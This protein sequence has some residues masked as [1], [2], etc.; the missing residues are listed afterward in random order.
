MMTKSAE[1]HD[2]PPLNEHQLAS[3]V[4]T[5]ALSLHQTLDVDLILQTLLDCLHDCVPYDS[6]SIMLLDGQ[7]FL[8]IRAARGYDQWLPESKQLKG[9]AFPVDKIS[10]PIYKIYQNQQSALIH[11]VRHEPGWQPNIGAG[12]IIRN[13]LGVPLIANGRFIGL[14]SLDKLEPNVFT[15]GHIQITEQIAPH[16][17]LAIQNA[18]LFQAEQTHALKLQQSQAILFQAEKAA[19]LGR[20]TTAISHE[21]NNPVQAIQGCLSLTRDE[22]GDPDN[23][24]HIDRYLDVIEAEA[25]RITTIINNL[26]SSHP[27]LIDN[28][29]QPCDI[30]IILD[31]VISKNEN[32]INAKN[33]SLQRK[34]ATNLPLI[35][36]N[37]QNLTQ[38]FHNIVANAVEA[39]SEPELLVLETM[40]CQPSL[41]Q[42]TIHNTGQPIPEH[43]QENLF[44]PFITTK[45][46]Q[47]GLGLFVT[48]SIIE[49]HGGQI[50]ATST[51]E[52]GTTFTIHLPVPSLP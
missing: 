9:T 23:Q 11:D 19:A 39:I 43:I 50:A 40:L 24:E 49:A 2:S 6:A 17:A 12:A 33:I 28:I 34:W 7:G 42:V 29:R 21:I 18:Q 15:K 10:L 48:Y 35:K 32:Q 14:I 30:N 27:T 13:W 37:K 52:H 45:D 5:A 26:R 16:A 44:E 22:M 8:V 4:V 47:F 20:L 3:S 25:T 38:A 1:V 51:A 41:I 36:A 46:K 31:E